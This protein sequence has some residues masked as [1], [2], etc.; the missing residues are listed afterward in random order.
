MLE[1]LIGTLREP[2][3]TIAVPLRAPVADVP[4][5]LQELVETVYDRYRYDAS[6]EYGDDPPPPQLPEPDIR[7]LRERVEAWQQPRSP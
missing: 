1:T 5:D 2:L 4:L 7:W 3:P 6:V